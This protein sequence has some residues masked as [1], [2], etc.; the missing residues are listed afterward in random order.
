[1]VVKFR[2]KKVCGPSKEKYEKITKRVRK[3]FGKSLTKGVKNL[4]KTLKY[5][6]ANISST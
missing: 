2:E 1:M 5:T 4:D 3:A 6:K